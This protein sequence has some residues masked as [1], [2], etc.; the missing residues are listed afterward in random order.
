MTTHPTQRETI[1][2]KVEEASNTLFKFFSNNDMVVNADKCHLLTGTSGEVSVKI[3]NE[4]IK[5]FL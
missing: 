3:E 5:N 1:L 2:K 4:I